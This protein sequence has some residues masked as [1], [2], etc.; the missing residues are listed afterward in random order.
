MLVKSW[1]GDATINDGDN[2]VSRLLQQGGMDQAPAS[3]QMVD[4]QGGF[5]SFAVNE[6]D[7]RD[8]VLGIV[9]KGADMETQRGE[10]IEMF[11]IRKGETAALVVTDDDGTSRERYVNA[12]PFRFMA[13]VQSSK[14]VYDFIVH[15]RVDGD[16]RF[17]A[18]TGDDQEW[19]VTATG[20]QETIN[21]GGDADAYPKFT[22]QPK[23]GKT[24]GYSY[25]RWVPI[26]WLVSTSYQKYPYMIGPENTTGW[27]M[28][29]DGDDLR[30]MVDGS[31]VDR[32]FGAASGV[33]GGPNSSTTKIWINLDFA[34]A[35]T[36]TLEASIG[37]G[38]TVTAIDVNEDITGFPS[39]GILMINSEAFVYTGKNNTDMRFTGVTRAAKGTAADDHAASDTVY[40]IQRDVWLIYGNASATAQSVDDDYKPILALATSTNTSWVYE[41]FGED[42][43]LRTG[44]WVS[45]C[46]EETPTFYTGNHGFKEDPWV[47][48]GI[49]ILNITGSGRW[50]L[51]NPCGITNANFTNGEKY[52]EVDTFAA[53]VASI[54]SKTGTGSWLSIYSISEPSLLDTWESWSRDQALGSDAV[55][56]GI[57][58][59][60]S[61]GH[62]Y[63]EVA[64]CVIALNS[65]YTPTHA[66]NDEEGNY[67]LDCTIENTT[68]GKAISLSYTM[69]L[70]AELEV[71]TL[72]KTIIDKEDELGQMQALTPVG[73]PRRDWL[74]LQGGDNV[75]EYTEAGAVLLIIDVEWVKRY[76]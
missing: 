24:G 18:V 25:K 69:A 2:Y 54:E 43:G 63:L 62:D 29:A 30:V 6:V 20:D 19:I 4:V 66:I 56:C 3:P 76:G 7:A 37:S 74:V 53:W 48:I 28:Q 23:T 45:Q 70:D 47:E 50:Y 8:L 17:R 9:C 38:D 57:Y 32:W 33:A 58:L 51:Y 75:L 52:R 46:V 60:S 61:F 71:D 36:A 67:S 21:N 26:K 73:G 34:P 13:A 16:Q 41:E 27:S 31:Q 14:V 49:E 5:P 68:T 44:A 59:Y 42:D 64:D 55:Y 12:A 35:Q 10:L 39:F 22:I 1:N 40:W 72:A 11:N 15:L 65:T